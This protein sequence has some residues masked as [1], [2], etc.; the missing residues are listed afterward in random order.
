MNRLDREEADMPEK[1][2]YR[3]V[4][5]LANNQRRRFESM[6]LDAPFSSTEG[7]ILHFILGHEDDVFQKDVEQEFG[8]RAP[9]AT[10]LLK[11]MEQKGLLSRVT[12]ESDGRR[13]KIVVSREAV[14][15]KEMLN[16]E[17]DRVE[18]QLTK[19]LDRKEI[20]SWKAISEKMIRNLQE[21]S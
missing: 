21:Q 18:T 1:T 16:R 20:E 10:E 9:S 2:V 6:A 17:L 14:K 5:M 13:K 11:S 19:G 12:S 4:N 7:K 8:M 15:Y 3:Y